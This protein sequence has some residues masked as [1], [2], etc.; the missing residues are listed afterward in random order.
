MDLSRGSRVKGRVSHTWQLPDYVGVPM[1]IHR[2]RDTLRLD[3]W[4]LV[5][6]LLLFV[7]GGHV[8]IVRIRI[9]LHKQVE[10]QNCRPSTSFEC[11]HELY[12]TA[13]V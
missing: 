7:C 13:C 5:T 11:T 9:P 10:V 1:N 2:A 8:R 4:P 3:T 6:S 12:R